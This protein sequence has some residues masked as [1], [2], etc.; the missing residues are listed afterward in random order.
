MNKQLCDDLAIVTSCFEECQ[1][2]E[3]GILT[4]QAKVAL[5][6][7]EL[8]EERDKR[9]NIPTIMY[10]VGTIAFYVCLVCVAVG[11]LL[12]ILKDTSYFIGVLEFAVPMIIGYFLRFM[13]KKLE[14]ANEKAYKDRLSAEVK[15]IADE[16]NKNIAIIKAAMN[17]FISKNARY[18]EMIPEKYRNLEAVSYMYLAVCN[19]RADTLKEVI[20]LYEEQLHRW[21]LEASAQ[22]AAEAQEFTAMALDE[23]NRQQAKTNNHLQTIEYL[24]YLNY[25]NNKDKS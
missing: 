17:D 9:D 19:G 5:A 18:I 15:P 24:E 2:M 13:G 14:S 21:R 25:L 22:Q 3:D 12:A 7:T 11:L 6:A 20:N 1:K 16:A 4:E 23:L 10:M 8:K